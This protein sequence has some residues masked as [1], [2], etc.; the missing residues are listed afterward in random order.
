MSSLQYH[1]FHFMIKHLV[2][3]GSVDFPYPEMR[4]RMEQPIIGLKR[5]HLDMSRG[6]AFE[7]VSVDGV[8]AE[9]VQTP[10]KE[11][12]RAILYLHGG[13]WVIGSIITHRHL[14][15]A[16]AKSSRARVLLIDYRLAPEYPFPAGLDDCLKAYRWLLDHGYRS[17]D[18]GIAGD[19]A[20]GNLA[21][22]LLLCLKEAGE[23]LP[24]AAVCLS[25]ATD[26]TEKSGDQH[27]PPVKDIILNPEAG[28]KWV[29]DYL[30]GHRP[31]DPYVSPLFGDL[32]NLPPI[33]I[34]VGSEEMLLQDSIRFAEKAMAAG[35]QVEV[36]VWPGLWHVWQA[37]TPF[38][39]E[40]R[41]ALEEVGKFF[42][43][44]FDL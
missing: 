34:Q 40:S 26:L 33:L 4:A 28:R 42:D 10:G 29:R 9:W 31:E 36:D 20:G 16:I 2:R 8:P 18:L 39:P 21:L 14:A 7:S 13:G 3:P 22:A 1:L 25:P 41:R 27:T 11:A 12:S 24:A 43:Q 23:P 15:A 44:H 35:S 37:F 17:Q 19:S 30:A 32:H 6:A 38:M 5:L